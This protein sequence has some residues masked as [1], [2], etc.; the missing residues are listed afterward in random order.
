MGNLLEAESRIINELE[1]RE[2]RILSPHATLSKDGRRRYP[3]RFFDLRPSFSRDADRIFHS[4]AFQKYIGRNQC[5]YLAEDDFR[6]HA[7]TCLQLVL[8]IS[9]IIA[10]ALALNEDLTEA[11]ALGHDIGHAPFGHAGETELSQ[12]VVRSF[13][14]AHFHFRQNVQ[15][16]R[17]LDD[18]EGYHHQ[19]NGRR[20]L[21]LTIQVLD[22]IL[23]H[24]S[25]RLRC[26]VSPQRE[27]TWADLI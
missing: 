8:K 16:I 12:E 5:V 15:A 7:A 18:L 11:I 6:H 1:R 13:G 27:K 17:F 24:R 10:R 20:S 9:K 25:D 2:K 22:G 21:N 19:S 26:S 4:F 14:D 3:E 23:C